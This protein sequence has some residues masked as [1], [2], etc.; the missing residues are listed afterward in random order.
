MAWA[1]QPGAAT[2]S[3]STQARTDSP[4]SSSRFKSR[5]A[6]TTWVESVRCFPPAATSPLSCN[7]ASSR[8]STRS[9]SP[10]A[11]TRARNSLSTVW[12]NPGSARSIPPGS[13]DALLRPRPLRTGRAA[14]T[15][16]GSSKPRGLADRQ[17]C[18]TAA[19]VR[20]LAWAAVGVY[21]ASG[22]GFVRCA[23]ARLGDDRVFADRVA[24]H[25]EPLFPLVGVLR[26]V[27]GVQQETPAPWTAAVL[28][29]EQTQGDWVQQ[30][31][32]AAA[33][34]RPEFGQGG[35][36][37]RRR[38]WHHPVPDDRRP[39]ES[40]QV[41]TTA[42]VPEH[43]LVVPGPVEGIEVPGDDPAF[44]L[45]RVG[46]SGPLVDQPPHMGVQRTERPLGHPDPVVGG[47]TPDDRVE[48]GDHHFGVGPSQGPRLGAEPFPDPPHGGLARLGQ[49]LAAE[50]ADVEPQEVT[51]LGEVDGAR[52]VLVEDQTPGRQPRGQPRLDL[53]GLLA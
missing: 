25:L 22:G 51:A 4:A 17:T 21:Q 26:F 1:S 45:V 18:W 9:S 24:D 47:P 13:G 44:R 3:A 49:Q 43:P 16:S 20:A 34:Q 12:S 7:A 52:L 46:V 8:S 31:F 2:A 37:D 6:P 23:V 11:T 48:S 5:T 36:V 50:P 27:V 10:W 30:G 38:S 15:A 35:V 41:K 40:S 53:L 32:P 39:G 14:P 28:R 19:D 33:P 42:A 29:P